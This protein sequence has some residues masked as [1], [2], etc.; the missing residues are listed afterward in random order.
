MYS[1]D[2]GGIYSGGVQKILHQKLRRTTNLN[3]FMLHVQLTELIT[4]T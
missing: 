4:M 2:H 1:Q 3:Y